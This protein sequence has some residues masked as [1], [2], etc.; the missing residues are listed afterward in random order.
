ME[1]P[2]QHP[3]SHDN[4]AKRA[5]WLT[6]LSL[7]FAFS[8]TVPAP[9]HEYG[10]REHGIC[11]YRSLCG[12]TETD[13]R[14]GGEKERTDGE[15]GSGKD[16]PE[17]KERAWGRK[18]AEREGQT[19]REWMDRWGGKRKGGWKGSGKTPSSCDAPEREGARVGE[20]DEENK[21]REGVD[22]WGGGKGESEEEGKQEGK[23]WKEKDED[24]VGREGRDER[25]QQIQRRRSRWSGV[26]EKKREREG[27]GGEKE[28]RGLASGEGAERRK[29]SKRAMRRKGRE[30]V[31][32]KDAE[33][34]GTNGEGRGGEE[35][36]ERQEGR[37]GK[38]WTGSE[39]REREGSGAPREVEADDA[40]EGVR[41]GWGEK[42]GEKKKGTNIN[43]AEGEERES[44]TN[45][46]RAANP[47][48]TAQSTSSREVWEWGGEKRRERSG[49]IVGERRARE[50]DGT[51]AQMKPTTRAE[52]EVGEEEEEK[53]REGGEVARQKEQRGRVG[54]VWMGFVWRWEGHRGAQGGDADVDG[55]KCI[56]RGEVTKRRRCGDRF[57]L[58]G[59]IFYPVNPGLER[60]APVDVRERVGKCDKSDTRAHLLRF[61]SKFFLALRLSAQ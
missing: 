31:G 60:R 42:R 22:G 27:V 38:E 9:Q 57:R 16:A 25:A 32:R 52:G 11:A 59:P 54:E 51:R 48:P 41:E 24:K 26:G 49:W 12:W 34:G 45:G 36:E 19:R 30:R 56:G 10:T 3:T 7:L 17:R 40:F 58:H 1:S 33:Q 61:P 46:A 53:W 35:R 23:E 47:E 18:N 15:R 43:G 21:G 6:R 14:E 44:R 2:P 37:D 20:E 5:Q 8:L 13:E 29:D 50:R 4:Q 28:G 39:G 55:R